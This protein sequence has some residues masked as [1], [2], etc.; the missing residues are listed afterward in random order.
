[1]LNSTE[2]KTEGK[3][4][5]KILVVLCGILI[6]TFLFSYTLEIFKFSTVGMHFM[7]RC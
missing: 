2:K 7:V 6:W 3:K 4:I 1:M 5:K